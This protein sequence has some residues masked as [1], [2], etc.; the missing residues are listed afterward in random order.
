MF[1][2]SKT[3]L[4]ELVARPATM[5][6]SE[7][8]TVSALGVSKTIKNLQKKGRKKKKTDAAK[9]FTTSAGANQILLHTTYGIHASCLCPEVQ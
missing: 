6:V 1:F 2:I 5:C 7:A 9:L 3:G 4:C 8:V